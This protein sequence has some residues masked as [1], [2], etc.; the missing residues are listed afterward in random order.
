MKPL[1]RTRR[2][3]RARPVPPRYL[4]HGSAR[5]RTANARPQDVPGVVSL[6][7]LRML[8]G[9]YAIG[10]RQQQR[11]TRVNKLD[12][13]EPDGEIAVEHDAL[14]EQIVDNVEQRCVFRPENLL[15]FRPPPGRL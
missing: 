12:S 5:F 15:G 13:R 11:Q 2:G 7:E 10:S 3:S 9:E 1:W 4:S 8:A 14:V 6:H